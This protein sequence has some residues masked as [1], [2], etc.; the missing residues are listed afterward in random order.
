VLDL[1]TQE[2]TV[3]DSRIVDGHSSSCTSPGS[4]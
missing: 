3:V 2:W 4:S 1:A